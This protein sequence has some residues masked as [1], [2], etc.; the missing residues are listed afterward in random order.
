MISAVILTKNEE[1]NIKACLDSLMWCEERIVVDDYSTDK[2]VE[3]AQAAGAKVYKRHLDHDF[4]QQRNYGLEKASQDWVFFVDADERV[5]DKLAY[6]IQALILQTAFLG[7][8]VYRRD[9]M[10]GK[11]LR[12]G[13]TGSIKLLRI[14]KKKAGKWVGKVHERW[15]IKGLT[16]VCRHTLK[17]YPHPSVKEFLEKIQLYTDF[18]AE[19]LFEKKVKVSWWQIIAYPK[20]KFF[21]NYILRLGFLDG[22]AGIVHALLMSLH[23]FLVRGKLWTLY[24]KKLA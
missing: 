15:D 2:T 7:V 21:L 8:Y 4:A 6:E 24:R 11:E 1:K 16:G 13:E 23:S 5:T 18:R 9:T 22:T 12:H 10:W 19:E 3:L 17:H 14:G 20:A